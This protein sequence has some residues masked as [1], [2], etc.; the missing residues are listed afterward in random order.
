M[1]EEYDFSKSVKNKY[2]KKLCMK[3]IDE[4]EQFEDNWD[5]YDALPFKKGYL[6][7]I[8]SFIEDLRN[9]IPQPSVVPINDGSIQLE[10][11]VNGKHLEMEITKTKKIMWLK[12]KGKI[13]KTGFKYDEKYEDGTIDCDDIEKINELIDWISGKHNCG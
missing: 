2:W 5:S 3:K 1:L 12:D 7:F 8:R 13:T 10:W 11:D 4:F 6:D 9:D